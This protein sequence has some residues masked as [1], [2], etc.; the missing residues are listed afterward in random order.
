MIDKVRITDP[1]QVKLFIHGL[2]ITITKR[3]NTFIQKHEKEDSK[4]MIR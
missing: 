3:C 1:K 4:A 2:K